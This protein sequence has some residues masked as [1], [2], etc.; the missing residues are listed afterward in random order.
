MDKKNLFANSEFKITVGN[1]LKAIMAYGFTADVL[2][3]DPNQLAKTNNKAVA[4]GDDD[5][6]F[7]NAFYEAL[8]SI[9]TKRHFERLHGSGGLE[10]VITAIVAA[11]C[12]GKSMLQIVDSILGHGDYDKHI[13]GKSK[14]EVYAWI[15]NSD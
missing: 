4:D 13:R 14:D 10:M 9:D 5:C 7:V 8:L 6:Q 12:E 15:Y 11:V 2:K 1:N 3:G